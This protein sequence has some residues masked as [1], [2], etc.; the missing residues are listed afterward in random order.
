M[1]IIIPSITNAGEVE[2][3]SGFSAIAGLRDFA[4]YDDFIAGGF[5][6]D[7]AL[8]NESDPSGKFCNLA[9][10][11]EWLVTSDADPTIV[12]ANAERGGLLLITTGSSANDFASLQMNGEAW[13]VT[14]GRDIWFECRVKFDDTNDTRWF[15]GLAST[16]VTGTTIGP[17]MDSVASGNSMIGFIQ[18]GDTGIEIDSLVQNGGTGTQTGEGVDLVDDTYNTLAFHVRSNDG[19]EFFIDG[20]SVGEITTNIPDGD[21]MTLS[22]EVHSPTASSTLEVDYIFCAQRR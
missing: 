5:V 21:A 15:I 14:A 13:A 11:G 4:Y 8:L 22:M 3:S 1:A 17:I 20:V 6:V 7:A 2:E 16:D 18:D 9:D 12:I 19:V 10:K